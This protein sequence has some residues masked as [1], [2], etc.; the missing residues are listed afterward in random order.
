MKLTH[1]E[2]QGIP[3]TLEYRKG[4]FKQDSDSPI[5]GMGWS[6]FADYGYF[7][8]TV[9]MEPGDALDV[10]VGES[11]ESPAAFFF[12]LRE[13]EEGVFSEYKV[14]LGFENLALAEKFMYAQYPSGMIGPVY[15]MTLEGL[16]EV[17][18][19]GRAAFEKGETL[20][21]EADTQVSLES[22][23]GFELRK[24]LGDRLPLVVFIEGC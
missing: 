8:E 14:C 10:Y 16:K 2:Y 23:Q 1:I 6:V 5:P 18:R 13:G 12:E 19:D 3:I 7:D 11:R 9:S 17:I 4:E 22:S 15:Q 20:E 21:E 24:S